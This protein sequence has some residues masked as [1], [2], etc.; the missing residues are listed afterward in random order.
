[1]SLAFIQ[2][3]RIWIT[4]VALMARMSATQEIYMRAH[5]SLLTHARHFLCISSITH[6]DVKTCVDS[7]LGAPCTF[8]RDVTHNHFATTSLHKNIR[9][10]D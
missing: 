5:E 2:H 9:E 6:K 4:I 1:M 10:A 7:H 3:V 8:T